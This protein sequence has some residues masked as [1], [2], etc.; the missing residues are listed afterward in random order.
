MLMTQY[1]L[2][3]YRKWLSIGYWARYL[4][5]W[6]FVANNS[7]QGI[8]VSSA[9]IY[10][11]RTGGNVPWW[12]GCT[13]AEFLP[14]TQYSIL[15]HYKLLSIEYW[16]IKDTESLYCSI[17]TLCN[18][19]PRD[20]VDIDFVV[21]N[22][23]SLMAINTIL[24]LQSCQQQ[25]WWCGDL[26]GGTSGLLTSSFAPCRREGRVTWPTHQTRTLTH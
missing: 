12:P 7:E 20:V 13:P 17:S 10:H 26:A 22:V 5:I 1:R 9:N 24:L 6:N 25:I 8:F 18:D 19:E 2:L 14:M 21:E 3:S 15:S 16:V 4:N 23:F 11:H